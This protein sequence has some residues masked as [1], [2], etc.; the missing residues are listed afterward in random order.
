MVRLAWSG[1]YGGI[2]TPHYLLKHVVP[3]LPNKGSYEVVLLS[4]SSQAICLP[5]CPRALISDDIFSQEKF[6]V[7]VPEQFK[8]FPNSTF[9]FIQGTATELNHHDRHVTVRLKDGDT[10]K[11]GYYALV[12][13]TGLNRDSEFLRASWNTVRAALPNAKKYHHRGGL[14]DVETAGELDE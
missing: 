8:Q 12:I 11:I 5:A 1:S 6:F 14:A 9:R 3:Q 10:E 7:S 4:T 2:S 13:A